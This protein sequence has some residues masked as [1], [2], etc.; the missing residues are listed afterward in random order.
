MTDESRGTGGV[1]GPPWSVDLLADLQAGV[2]DEH[3]AAELWPRVEADPEAREIIAALEA[4]SSDLAGLGSAPVEPMPA[5]F[6][7]R[8]DAAL[9]EEARQHFAV[10]APRQ[11]EPA[12]VVSLDA[13]RQR[14]K[15]RVGWATGIVAVAAAAVAAIA[16][17][18]PSGNTPGTPNVAQPPPGDGEAPLALQGDGSNASPAQAN[19]VRDFGPL[20]SQERLDSCLTANGFDASV[21]PVG[22]RPVTVDGKSAVLVVLTTGKLAQ[23]RLVAFPATCGPGGEGPIFDKFVG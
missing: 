12:P 5:E 16:I 23:F 11:S 9:A 21:K 13:A 4:T 15:K 7:A 22:F 1:V 19:G 8:L 20:G 2:L 17:V 18:V 3:T 6:A 14:R 10:P